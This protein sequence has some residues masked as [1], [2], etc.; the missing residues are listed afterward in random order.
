LL[1]LPNA[2]AVSSST[3]Q[4]LCEEKK[5]SG[6]Y[7]WLDLFLRNLF[8]GLHTDRNMDMGRKGKAD[9][10]ATRCLFLSY[11]S[12]GLFTDVKQDMAPGRSSVNTP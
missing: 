1:L 3:S 9:D 4:A 5:A 11:I 7:D 12:I 2:A 8:P 10:G 6:K